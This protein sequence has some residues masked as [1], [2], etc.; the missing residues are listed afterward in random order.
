MKELSKAL[1]TSISITYLAELFKHDV[2]R[3]IMP[4]TFYFRLPVRRSLRCYRL[5]NQ[6]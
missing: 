6:I 3:S 1:T 4:Y 2:D 5:V